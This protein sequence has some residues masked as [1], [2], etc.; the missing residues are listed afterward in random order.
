[1]ALDDGGP[2]GWVAEELDRRGVPVVRVKPSE[3]AR[4]CGQFAE[5][6][7]VRML[8]HLSDPRLNLSVAVADKAPLGAGWRW[9]RKRSNGDVSPLIAAT[10]AYAVAV[11]HAKPYERAAIY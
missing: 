4:A 2:V 1:V 6:A 7:R 9:D 8:A 3:Y 10:L 5:A 11:T